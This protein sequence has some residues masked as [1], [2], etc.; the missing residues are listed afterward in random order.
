MNY[1]SKLGLQ[2]LLIFQFNFRALIYS[3]TIIL[4][5]EYNKN[6]AGMKRLYQRRFYQWMKEAEYWEIFLEA[7]MLPYCFL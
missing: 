3:V 1:T 2:S 5:R 7:E 4:L 6:K